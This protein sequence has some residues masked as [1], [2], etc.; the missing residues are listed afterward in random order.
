MTP[1]RSGVQAFNPLEKACAAL[2]LNT[3]ESAEP[4]AARSY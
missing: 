2:G 4:A 3:A 1:N